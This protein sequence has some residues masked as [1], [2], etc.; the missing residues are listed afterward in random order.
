MALLQILINQGGGGPCLH[1]QFLVD[2]LQVFFLRC[3]FAYSGFD[4]KACCDD[5]YRQY[6]HVPY[7]TGAFRRWN[8]PGLLGARNWSSESPYRSHWEQDSSAC[9][10]GKYLIAVG[11]LHAPIHAGFIEVDQFGN[12]TSL[13][14][15][16]MTASSNTV[17]FKTTPV[18]IDMGAFLGNW[19]LPTVSPLATGNNTVDIV[20]DG[21]YLLRV[22]SDFQTQRFNVDAFG[23]VTSK[24]PTTMTGS[25]STLSLITAPVHFDVG[26]YSRPWRVIDALPPVHITGSQTVHLA[27]DVE[28]K[29][30]LTLPAHPWNSVGLIRVA[31][32]HPIR[33]NLS[34]AVSPLTLA[35]AR[36]TARQRRWL[37]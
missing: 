3:R 4:R 35:A 16:S 11:F 34:S 31:H 26:S 22:T 23:I 9:P 2:M 8:L 15:T 21:D 27:T 5:C 20:P 13:K 19:T 29:V 37:P 33:H 18:T 1:T 14:P 30:L 7:D 32:A 6:H 28:Y 25:G 24:K 36:P 12:V 10:H 17:N